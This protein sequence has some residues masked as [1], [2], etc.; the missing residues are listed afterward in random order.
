MVQW[1]IG[2]CLDVDHVEILKNQISKIWKIVP[3]EQGQLLP[4]IEISL[5]YSFCG[6]LECNVVLEPNGP[7]TYPFI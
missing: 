3:K 4:K 1:I 6:L 2:W 7:P 5:P